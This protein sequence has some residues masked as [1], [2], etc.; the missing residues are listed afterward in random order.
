MD[1]ALMSHWGGPLYKFLI[2]YMVFTESV[3]VLFIL[4]GLGKFLPYVF[5]A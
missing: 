1:H 3:F 5:F 4:V 2:K